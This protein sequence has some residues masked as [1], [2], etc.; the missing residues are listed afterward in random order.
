MEDIEQV[1]GK[2]LFGRERIFTENHEF[3]TIELDNLSDNIVTESRQSVAVGNHQYEL[4]AAHCAFQNGFKTFAL[5]VESTADVFDNFGLRVV[6]LHEADLSFEVVLLLV[7]GHTTI[8][9][10]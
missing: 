8:A 3:S 5:E 4:I 7:T 9:D 1:F 2:F 10:G 6:F